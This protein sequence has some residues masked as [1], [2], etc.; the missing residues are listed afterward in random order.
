MLAPC[1]APCAQ[2]GEKHPPSIITAYICVLWDVMLIERDT[3]YRIDHC[4]SHIISPI[5][6]HLSRLYMM[7]HLDIDMSRKAGKG[8]RN[9]GW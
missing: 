5:C 3:Q 2:E 1:A 7:F 9:K 4:Q 6:H 8:N